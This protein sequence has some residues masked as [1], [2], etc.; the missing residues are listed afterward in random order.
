M[1]GRLFITVRINTL[2]FLADTSLGLCVY[3]RRLVPRCK[4]RLNYGLR[5]PSGN[6]ISTYG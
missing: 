2:L 6:S 5:E 1:T 4:K 3:P